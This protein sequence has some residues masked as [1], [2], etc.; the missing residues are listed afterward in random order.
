MS[1]YRYRAPV[2]DR[3]YNDWHYT[4][5]NRCSY[6]DL[7]GV[8]VSPDRRWLALVETTTDPGKATSW[9]EWGARQ[10]NIPA[11][12]VIYPV[13]ELYP[14]LRGE[15]LVTVVTKWWPAPEGPPFPRMMEIP[16]GIWGQWIEWLH[17]PDFIDGA[18]ARTRPNVGRDVTVPLL[19]AM[20]CTAYWYAQHAGLWTDLGHLREL[21]YRAAVVAGWHGL[22]PALVLEG[23]YLV[24]TWPQWIWDRAAN[25]D[26]SQGRPVSAGSR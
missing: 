7:D 16:L 22:G 25:R 19:P 13:R 6:F 17:S 2:T 1:D 18:Y 26:H 21:D 14:E 4:L 5:S 15:V 12:L 24:H 23:P 20:R 10:L 3:R 11:F 9:T 8:E